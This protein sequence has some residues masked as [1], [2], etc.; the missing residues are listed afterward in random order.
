VSAAAPNKTDFVMNES[1]LKSTGVPTTP[2]ER[3]PTLDEA[4]ID[5][6]LAKRAREPSRLTEPP[7]GCRAG[8]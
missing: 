6:N 7:I 4:G 2:V 3:P 8:L 5:K 1:P